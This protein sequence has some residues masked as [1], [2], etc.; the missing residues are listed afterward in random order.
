M[1]N[2]IEVKIVKGNLIITMPIATN[3]RPSKS[4]KTL[5]LGTTGGNRPTGVS[6]KVD[7]QD[8]EI[9]MGCTAYIYPPK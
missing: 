1:A 8:Q 4:G 6:L 7:G 3:P 9:V 2:E 5:I